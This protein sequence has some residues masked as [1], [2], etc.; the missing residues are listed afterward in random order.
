MEEDSF[1]LKN[2]EKSDNWLTTIFG[3]MNAGMVITDHKA[4][5][6]PIIYANPKF[7][8]MTGYEKKDIIGKNCRF[9]Q[10]PDTDKTMVKKIRQT[11]DK[12]KKGKFILKNYKKDGT[13]FFNELHLAPIF[14]KEGKLTH[15]IGIQHDVT[16]E[17]GFGV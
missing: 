8:E 5:D 13:E 9:L 10:G 7:Y 12:G 6:Q 4:K 17:I 11:I 1:D 3:Y 15:Y 14:S 2:L 16:D